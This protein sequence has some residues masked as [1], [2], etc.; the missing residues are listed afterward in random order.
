[1]PE[2]PCDMREYTDEDRRT[3]DEIKSIMQNDEGGGDNS[4]LMA[5]GKDKKQIRKQAAKVDKL[6]KAIPTDDIGQT[7]KLAFAAAT[8]ISQRIESRNSAVSN[9]ARQREPPWKRRIEENIKQWRKD[10]S[11]LA[12]I[13]RNGRFDPCADRSLLKYQV[14]ERGVIQVTEELRQKVKAA[15]QKIKRFTERTKQYQQNRLF[16][17]DQKR[18]YQSLDQES[19]QR[20]LSPNCDEAKEFWSG[21]WKS[22]GSHNV[23][24]SWLEEV[25][26]KYQPIERQEG[27]HIS[28][29]DVTNALGKMAPWKAPG[30]D[31]VH[32]FWL[33]Q[34][35]SLHHRIATQ[36]Q[37]CVTNRNPTEWMTKGRTVLIMKDPAKGNVP[38]NFRPIT[39]LPIM[40]KLLTSI[41]SDHIYTHLSNNNLLQWE[42]KGCAKSSRGTKDHLLLDKA[43]M[44]DCKGRHTNLSMG[45]I[46]Y[47][48]AY[49]MVPHS[50]VMEVLSVMKVSSDICMFLGESMKG[51]RT[52]LECE[53]KDL[54]EVNI[55]RGIFQG[56][57]LSPLLF[58]MS[59]MPLTDLLR[60][61]KHGY[62]T[63]QQLSVNHLL[64]MDDLKLYA[65]SRAQLESLV[66]TVKIFSEDI[67]MKFGLEKCAVLELR[68][69]KFCSSENLALYDDDSIH[70]LQ[71][72]EDY[73]YLGLWESDQFKSR[74]IKTKIVDK[75][76]RRLRKVLKS[77]LNGG[78]VIKAINT[79]AVSTI[80]YSAGILSWSKEEVKAIDRKTRKIMTMYGGHHP[81][82]D[83]DRL[84]VKR[85]EGGRGLKSVEETIMEEEQSLWQYMKRSDDDLHVFTRKAMK[86]YGTATVCEFRVKTSQ[87][88]KARW[89]DKTMGGQFLRQTE[90]ITAEESWRWLKRGSLKRETESL[91]IAA[92]DQALRTNY[93][94]AKVEKSGQPATCRMCKEKDE[95]VSHII[96][97]CSKLAQTDYKQRHDRV[98]TAVHWS[99]CRK[100]GIKVTSEWYKHTAEKVMESEQA[101]LLWDYNIMTDKVITARRPDIV[102]V[103]KADNH[104]QLIDIAVPGDTRVEDKE[105]EKVDKYQDLAREVRTIWRVS[106]EVIPIVIGALGTLSI[107]HRSFLAQ[108]HSDMSSETIQKAALLG[109][110]RILRK[111]LES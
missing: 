60:S 45:W 98:A 69:G 104:C 16:E 110:A 22:G 102:V 56:D 95:T 70:S 89:K 107:R 55:E 106:T 86:D 12:E 51:W 75:Y 14:V 43:I 52:K 40:W 31:K 36:L 19:S 11:K 93:R 37:Q 47:R 109:T 50:W 62:K 27:I 73:K 7:N 26:E 48:K 105:N 88:R 61:A 25:K 100:Y 34:F 2:E 80:R 63:N 42:Q 33:K 67:G 72:D 99:L 24:A 9:S 49:D 64:F 4:I 21:I 101:K 41:I 94:K 46:D 57:S 39:C 90:K 78:N 29:Q 15:A 53:G 96:S 85:T 44:K 6:L 38:S 1:M 28:E 84:Y 97:E 91:V 83:V 59:M 20:R 103:R 5:K 32:A 10:L 92:Q 65:K 30:H 68:R 13:E 81:R 35:G 8:F 87:E 66:K 54:C 77:K 111:V 58:V 18:F 74:K 82:A 23:S 71:E 108:L 17:R 76:Y 3:I 79:W